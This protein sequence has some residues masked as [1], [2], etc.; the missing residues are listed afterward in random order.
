MKAKYQH[1]KDHCFEA[2]LSRLRL[3]EFRCSPTYSLP[4]VKWLCLFRQLHSPGL[5]RGNSASTSS[6][7]RQQP[8]S[9]GPH[10]PK[11][12]LRFSLAR[13]SPHGHH[14]HRPRAIEGFPARRKGSGEAFHRGPEPDFSV[15]VVLPPQVRADPDAPLPDPEPAPALL[16]PPAS[17]SPEAGFLYARKLTCQVSFKKAMLPS[18]KQL[19]LTKKANCKWQHNLV[20][21]YIPGL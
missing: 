13:R 9:A 12:H 2:A 17:K 5:R 6:T 15:P 11:G 21:P 7:V 4:A 16:P 3:L 8:G 10:Q 19:A 18:V 20:W 14:Q 1:V